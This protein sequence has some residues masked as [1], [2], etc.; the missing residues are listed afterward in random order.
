MTKHSC[1]AAAAAS[2]GRHGPLLALLPT[3]A[4]ALAAPALAQGGRAR[5]TQSDDYTRYELLAPGSGK[6]RI[7]Y[8]VTATTAGATQFFNAIRSGSVASD[9]AV[10]DRMTGKPLKFDEVGQDVARAGGV[11]GGRGGTID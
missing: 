11:G 7:L 3:L 2:C 9:E 5:Q 4:L 8:E 10:Y 1:G 6:F